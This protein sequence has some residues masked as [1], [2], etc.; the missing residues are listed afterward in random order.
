M[1]CSGIPGPRTR[2]YTKH[3]EPRPTQAANTVCKVKSYPNMT[4]DPENVEPLNME[5]QRGVLDV[6][7]GAL[8]P[9]SGFSSPHRVPLFFQLRP[10]IMAYACACQMNTLAGVRLIV[11][12]TAARALTELLRGLGKLCLR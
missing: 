7:N 6:E 11:R 3:A 1:Y 4:S 9:V 10:T 12:A 5:K 8:A 2:D